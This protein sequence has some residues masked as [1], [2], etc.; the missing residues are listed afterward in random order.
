MTQSN[1][2]ELGVPLLYSINLKKEK[3][4]SDGR[5]FIIYTRSRAV[6]LAKLVKQTYLNRAEPWQQ[7]KQISQELEFGLSNTILIAIDDKDHY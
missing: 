7:F 3:V 1:M 6:C 4:H 2:K 5:V